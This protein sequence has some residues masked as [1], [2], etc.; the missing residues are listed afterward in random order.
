MS[1]NI[2]GTFNMCKH[3]SKS[4]IGVVKVKK[5]KHEKHAKQRQ[6]VVIPKSRD[7][8]VTPIPHIP[9]SKITSPLP[10]KN[11]KNTHVT[12]A[13]IIGIVR[14][15]TYDL[16]DILATPNTNI[17]IKAKTMTSNVKLFK[18]KVVT[19]RTMDTITFT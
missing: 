8:L 3:C 14:N 7:D 19:I 15:L 6:N 5:P 9:V 1:M 11:I 16:I 10:K 18:I 17:L 4:A 12:T 13:N 2:T